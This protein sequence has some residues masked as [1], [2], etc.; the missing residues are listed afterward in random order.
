[1]PL[2]W[3]PPKEALTY[4]GVTVYHVH[5]H[6][7]VEEVSNFWFRLAW[8]EDDEEFDARDLEVGDGRPQG[9]E[10]S[11]ERVKLA[12]DLGQ[13]V[14]RAA[15]V[16]GVC[17]ECHREIPVDTPDGTQCAGEGCPQVLFAQRPSDD[18]RTFSV[19]YEVTGFGSIE[20][21]AS[22]Q[23]EADRAVLDLEL[24]GGSATLMAQAEV[25]VEVTK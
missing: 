19:S 18:L 11:L 15:Y 25:K 10:A 17:P 14:V 8:D 24:P 1:M 9:L 6:D 13:L 5:R 16:G 20:M 7:S 22:T 3:V 23:E 12:I 4:K 21:E 2:A